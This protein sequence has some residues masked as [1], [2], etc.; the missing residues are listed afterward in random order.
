MLASMGTTESGTTRQ[1]LGN[2]KLPNGAVCLSERADYFSPRKANGN[3]GN[4]EH[5]QDIGR[6]RRPGGESGPHREARNGTLYSRILAL[7]S[8]AGN[9][10]VAQLLRP[11]D[12]AII[13]L[14]RFGSAEHNA[15]G[16][17][18]SAGA[19]T[20]IELGDGERLTYGE[21]VALAGDFFASLG[22]MRALATTP[23]GQ[24]ELRGGA[25]EGVGHRNSAL[26]GGLVTHNEPILPTCRLEY[27]P[28][29]R[30]R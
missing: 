19:G 23:Q 26:S 27:F 5:T 11:A 24:A 1:T 20:D 18:A 25:L 7:N 14:S 22:Q 2:T 17:D 9:A 29:L 3:V 6:E 30:W 8:S 12:R 28:F 10:A 16:A 13:T 4:M 15:I 21:M